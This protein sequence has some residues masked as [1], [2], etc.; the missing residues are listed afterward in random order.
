MKQLI[1]V[2]HPLK[3][4]H[5]KENKGNIRKVKRRSLKS[6]K[7][8]SYPCLISSDLSGDS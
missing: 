6:L 3:I 1:T 8:L 4:F 7:K 5:L 2:H